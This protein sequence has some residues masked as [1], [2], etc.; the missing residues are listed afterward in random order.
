[1]CGTNQTAKLSNTWM[2]TEAFHSC[3]LPS[4]KMPQ[5]ML[6]ASEILKVRLLIKEGG[7]LAGADE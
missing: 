1:M 4:Y 5:A 2:G 3:A 7:S 6:P